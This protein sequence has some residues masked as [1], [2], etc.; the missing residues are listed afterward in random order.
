[1]EG[2]LILLIINKG[3]IF[4]IKMGGYLVTCMKMLMNIFLRVDMKT[5]CLTVMKFGLVFF[6]IFILVYQHFHF[7]L[8][9]TQ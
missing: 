9:L 8:K 1:M 2:C 5:I 6:S 4:K 3:K 7:H